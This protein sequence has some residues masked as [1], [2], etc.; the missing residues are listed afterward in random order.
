MKCLSTGYD[1]LHWPMILAGLG[2]LHLKLASTKLL[3]LDTRV[4]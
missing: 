1:Y 3:A 2:H 4:A